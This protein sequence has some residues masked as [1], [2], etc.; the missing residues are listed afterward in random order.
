MQSY[1][2]NKDEVNGL[3]FPFGVEDLVGGRDL[4][5]NNHQN[6]A[7]RIGIGCKTI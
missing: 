3:G 4:K 2:M 7:E 1:F 5:G 6:P